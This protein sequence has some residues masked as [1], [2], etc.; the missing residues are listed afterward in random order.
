MRP[1][2]ISA[3]LL[4][5][6]TCSLIGVLAQVDPPTHKPEETLTVIY[7]LQ[8]DMEMERHLLGL[9]MERFLHLEERRRG[10]AESVAALYQELNAMMQ[11]PGE[12]DPEEVAA[13]ESELGKTE[14]EETDV[15]LQLRDS[16]GRIRR[17]RTR[18][19]FIRNRI[20][21][22]RSG[23]PS[24]TESLTGRWQVIYLPMGD[25]GWFQLKQTGTLLG[26]EYHLE[27]GW[28]GSLQGT[29]IDGKVFLQRID[30]KLGRFSELQGYL[31]SDG[32]SIKGSW[33]NFEL[34]GIDPS[35]GSW[36]ATKLDP[37][38]GE[39]KP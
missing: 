4:V 8:V 9:E 31:S 6:A 30:S 16:R 34:S 38:D 36:S 29:F 33:Q 21:V 27:G 14:Q 18:V 19:E 1:G 12:A 15:R 22:L 11:G 5:A 37:A 24:A 20:G 3:G 13:K 35:S 10:L 32:K 7:A 39:E 17:T 23:L 26:G 25:R 28:K 2:T